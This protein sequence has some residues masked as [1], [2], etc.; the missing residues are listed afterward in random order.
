MGVNYGRHC[1]RGIK[2]R[3]VT[4]CTGVFFAER[5]CGEGFCAGVGAF[6]RARI[7]ST[8]SKVID[9]NCGHVINREN[10]C[11]RGSFIRNKCCWVVV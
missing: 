9:G 11:Q 4:V 5:F 6:S 3:D 7:L 2:S 1:V 8:C 10:N